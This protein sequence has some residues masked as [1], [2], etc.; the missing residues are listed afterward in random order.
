MSGQHL[1]DDP[2]L[3][4]TDEPREFVKRKKTAQDRIS[5]IGGLV[6]ILATLSGGV[7]FVFGLMPWVRTDVYTH[8]SAAN[9]ARV[10]KVETAA[11][12]LSASV[13]AI[14]RNGLL[15]L[16]LQLQQ[17]VDSLTAALKTIP[18]GSASYNQLSTAYYEAAQQLAEVNR[19]LGR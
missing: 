19:Q 9:D 11:Q 5:M 16:Q 12:N 17:R 3:T 14:Q 4:D 10:M 7:S 6:A 13:A 1:P 2:V 8:D 18:L 15:T